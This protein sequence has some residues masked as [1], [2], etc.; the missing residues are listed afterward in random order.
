V[1]LM[2]GRAAREQ[3]QRPLCGYMGLLVVRRKSCGET[4]V[5]VMTDI[6]AG[7]P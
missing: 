6:S 7:L 4:V 2:N 1:S 5:S 3:I